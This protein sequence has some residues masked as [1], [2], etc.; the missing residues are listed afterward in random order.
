MFH[1]PFHLKFG[2]ITLRIPGCEPETTFFPYVQM[3]KA[4][5]RIVAIARHLGASG[6]A[7]TQM[8]PKKSPTV[9]K[10]VGESSSTPYSKGDALCA[11]SNIA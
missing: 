6:A 1:L 2:I 7:A 9:A 4:W 8:M 5:R 3:R 10:Q 11:H